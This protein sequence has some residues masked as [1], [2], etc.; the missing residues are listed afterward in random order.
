MGYEQ[1]GTLETGN[2]RLLHGTLDTI[3]QGR[4]TLSAVGEED[5]A[6]LVL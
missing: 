6:A 1:H 5:S 3:Q 2:D 4:T